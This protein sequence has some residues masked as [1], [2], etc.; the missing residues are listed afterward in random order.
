MFVT[1]TIT[2]LKKAIVW[3]L[4]PSKGHWCYTNTFCFNI[5]HWS[6]FNILPCIFRYADIQPKQ[7]RLLKRR[8][9]RMMRRRK[10]RIRR[11]PHPNPR[12]P[13]RNGWTPPSAKT[14]TNRSSGTSYR[15]ITVYRGYVTQLLDNS[16]RGHLGPYRTA[17]PVHTDTQH[18]LLWFVLM[19][20]EILY[21]KCE[22]FNNYN[23]KREFFLDRYTYMY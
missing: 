13:R 17:R 20:D 9:R 14:R 8:F 15:G 5:W 16:A 1:I 7:Q 4:F 3:T 21:V 22:Y 12:G 11:T 23:D 10:K 2:I 6:I 18:F 19:V